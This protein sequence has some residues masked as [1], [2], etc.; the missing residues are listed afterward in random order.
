MKSLLFLCVQNRV[1]SP[2]A[3][4]LARH[5]IGHQ[6]DIFS[7]GSKPSDRIHPM[8]VA[9]MGEIGIDI[10][11]LRPKALTDIDL[12]KI[13][14]AI[15]LCDDK[16]FP[17]LPGTLKQQH[18]PTAIPVEANFDIPEDLLRKFRKI[19]DDL[20]KKVL[21]LRASDQTW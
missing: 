19:R 21:E 3:E 10:S 18:W 14:T 2:I 17:A 20:R 11:A 6:Y 5:F 9:V 13:D 16:E 7:A 12:T 1:S 4:G 15:L 8:A